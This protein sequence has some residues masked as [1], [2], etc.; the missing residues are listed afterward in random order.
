MDVSHDSFQP[1]KALLTEW[2]RMVGKII[3]LLMKKESDSDN[4]EGELINEVR[5]AVEEQL[6]S[7]VAHCSY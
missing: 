2:Q 4:D 7:D 6:H 1:S 3:V 5:T